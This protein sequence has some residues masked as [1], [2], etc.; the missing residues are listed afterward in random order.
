MTALRG[1]PAGA[2]LVLEPRALRLHDLAI[3]RAVVNG[4]SVVKAVTRY[5]PELVDARVKQSYFDGAL[6][7]AHEH[8]V[9]MGEGFKAQ[10]LMQSVGGG[11][12]QTAEAGTRPTLDEYRASRGLDGFSDQEVLEQLDGEYGPEVPD[13]SK[14]V[15]DAPIV[16]A[17]LAGLSVL[18]L[19]YGVAPGRSDAASMWLSPRICAQ[20]RPFGVLTLADVA[21][22]INREGRTW[23]RTV[24]GLGRYRAVQLTRWLH[25]HREYLG[26]VLSVRVTQEHSL[27]E[28]RWP[29]ATMPSLHSFGPNAL[30]AKTDAEAVQAWLK[31]LSLK[32]PH[33]LDAY[34]RDVQRLLM[35]A[36]ERELG[37]A[38]LTVGDAVD[39]AHFLL[40]PPAHWVNRLPAA[41][42]DR[43]WTPM[44][45]PLSVS[46]ANRALA[47][48]GHFY[49]F[50]V[51][52][53]YLVAN[54]FA[55]VRS[56]P[57]AKTPHTV[58]DTTR[59]FGKAHI[60]AMQVTLQAMPENPTK[61]RL[62]A[63]LA[64]AETTGLR[65]AEMLGHTWADL[66]RPPDDDSMW[67][68]RVVGKGNRERM[69]PIR[70]SVV[71]ALERHRADR[72][73]LVIQ[74]VVL[75]VPDGQEPLL[76]ILERGPTKR[77]LSAGHLSAAGLH[78]V[79]KSFFRSVAKECAPH[80]AESFEQASCH[81]LRHTFAHDV[82]KASGNDLTVTQQLLAHKNLSTTGLY[83]KADMSSRIAAVKALP[84]RYNA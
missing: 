25:D 46:S 78:R 81:W 20:L 67:M 1:R 14:P 8:L 59:A 30:G 74:G 15:F 64:F 76:S 77:P 72:A 79:L 23:W 70:P 22:L 27:V 50:L 69:V 68:L 37:L 35:W 58:I 6:A 10:S 19:K 28:P 33:T 3:L 24:P 61:R 18:Q 11:G 73:S 45:G 2:E 54:P 71:Q 29:Q 47:A 40:D 9:G 32:S 75:P 65:R 80:V 12:P 56:A 51:D 34:R 57:G 39:H 31:T 48:I 26:N 83:L 63:V 38:T 82:L 16:H 21:T 7:E 55:A 4:L 84:E 13:A 17:A 5:L 36:H 44:R 66:K 60:E 49:R 42:K 41:R 52:T 62:M 43:D 53:A